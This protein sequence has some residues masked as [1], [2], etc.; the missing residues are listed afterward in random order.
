MPSIENNDFF[1]KKR[2]ASEIKSEILN[3][4]FKAWCGI[5]L[6]GQKYKT[7]KRLLYIDLYAGRGYY[8]DGSPSTPIEILESIQTSKGANIDLDGAVQTFFNDSNKQE[9]SRLKKNIETLNFYNELTHKPIIL[10]RQADKDLLTE[11]LN[12]NKEYPSLTFLDPF[13]YSYSKEMLMKAVKEWG[14]DLFFLFNINRVQAAVVN[15]AVDKIM[16][17]IFGERYALIRDFYGKEDRPKEREKFIVNQI[18]GLFKENNFLIFKFRIKF[19]DRDQ[20]SHY[21]FFVTKV[22]V[23]YTKMKEI[24]CPY[25]DRQPD[26]VPYFGANIKKKSQQV[27][28]FFHNQYE[29]SLEKLKSDLL[30]NIRVH[31]GNTIESI[32]KDHNVGTN[33]IKENYKQALQELHTEEKIQLID[34]KANLAERITYTCTVQANGTI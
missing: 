32:Y 22:K 12:K 20:T 5:L 9:V 33:Y 6:Y 27:S 1:Q 4:Y 14:S 30:E 24:M 25:S 23:A 15:G 16:A 8:D 3:K 28:L 18:E 11:L 7:V 21:L 19:P 31:C 26:G 2:E 17:E 34:R 13:G 29:F 10:N